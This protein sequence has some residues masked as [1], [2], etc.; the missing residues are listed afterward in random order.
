MERDL[1]VSL[2]QVS[3]HVFGTSQGVLLNNITDIM[4]TQKNNDKVDS[5]VWWKNV[6]TFTQRKCTC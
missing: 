3:V 2:M 5:Q 6:I 4:E 1:N